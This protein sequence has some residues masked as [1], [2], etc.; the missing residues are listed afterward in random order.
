MTR[1]DIVLFLEN[2]NYT[3]RLQ[4][5]E[6]QCPKDLTTEAIIMVLLFKQLPIVL[7][8]TENLKFII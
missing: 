4:K 2:L 3:N 5:R 1:N 7:T 6:Q 8:V